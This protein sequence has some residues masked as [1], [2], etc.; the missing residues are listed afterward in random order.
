MASSVF[1]TLCLG[2]TMLRKSCVSRLS[3]ILD[4]APGNR[5]GATALTNETMGNQ[6]FTARPMWRDSLY[7]SRLNHSS[8]LQC[9]KSFAIFPVNITRFSLLTKL[10]S[11]SDSSLHL[12]SRFSLRSRNDFSS[13]SLPDLPIICLICINECAKQKLLKRLRELL[14]WH[15]AGPISCNLL[16]DLC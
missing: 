9:L 7:S 1:R 8:R 11:S 10:S 2:S 16:D 15:S 12:L 13:S 14:S 4:E 6:A 5:A 3:G